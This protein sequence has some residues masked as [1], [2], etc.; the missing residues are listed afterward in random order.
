MDG[1]DGMGLGW[2]G[3]VWWWML[4]VVAL[5]IRETAKRYKVHA[6]HGGRRT[7]TYRNGVS[8]YMPIGTYR[9][10]VLCTGYGT[11][12]PLLF[13]SLNLK[14]SLWPGPDLGSSPPS[15]WPLPRGGPHRTKSIPRPGPWSAKADL[16]P[17]TSQLH[18]PPLSIVLLMTQ[19]QIPWEGVP[20]L[21]CFSGKI[22]PPSTLSHHSPS[23]GTFTCPNPTQPGTGVHYIYIPSPSPHRLLLPVLLFLSLPTTT[24]SQRRPHL[25]GAILY[26]RSVQGAIL[27]YV[28]HFTWKSP[29]QSPRTS[30]PSVQAQPR[31][32]Q[33]VIAHLDLD[34]YRTPYIISPVDIHLVRRP[35]LRR[36]PLHSSV[37]I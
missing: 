23:R 2:M 33:S 6:L 7:G 8:K 32:H 34:L 25:A 5:S 3:G 13:L 11:Y 24:T 16:P 36:N 22:H 10:V 27:T 31:S 19:A 15:P 17:S 28:V 26:D 14:T 18:C 29:P 35:L 20:V 12:P 30:S 37:T 9:F 21:R 4:F 1:W